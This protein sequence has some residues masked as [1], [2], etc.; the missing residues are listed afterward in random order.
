MFTFV[1]ESVTFMACGC[2]VVLGCVAVSG[3]LSLVVFGCVLGFNFH[4]VSVTF[5]VLGCVAVSG[6]FVVFGRVV[7][8]FVI[9]ICTLFS[10]SY[11]KLLKMYSF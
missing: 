4:A 6:S 1:A 5:M 10:K 7:E 9:C 3:P 11:I 2:F 8:F